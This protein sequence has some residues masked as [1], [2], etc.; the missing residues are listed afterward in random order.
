MMI[1]LIFFSL[2]AIF[3][4]PLILDSSFAENDSIRFELVYPNGDRM[5]IG[6][7]ILIVNSEDGEIHLEKRGES[8]DHY[9]EI[10]LP[11]EKK[12]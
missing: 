4:A 7:S 10:D 11:L 3:L 8:Q 1:H 9:F 12:I 5:P 2:L 6:N